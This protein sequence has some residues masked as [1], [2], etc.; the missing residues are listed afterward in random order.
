M[1]HAVCSCYY[2]YQDSFFLLVSYR[3][4]KLFLRVHLLALCYSEFYYLRCIIELRT[5]PLGCR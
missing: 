1:K 5:D 2:Q 4:I 3:L